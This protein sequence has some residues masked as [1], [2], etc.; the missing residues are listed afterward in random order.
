VDV[1]TVGGLCRSRSSSATQRSCRCRPRLTPR[2][3]RSGEPRR[4]LWASAAMASNLAA[5]RT[6]SSSART[7]CTRRCGFRPHATGCSGEGRS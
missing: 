2:Y 6:W 5:R 3:P 1:D 7:A 4:A